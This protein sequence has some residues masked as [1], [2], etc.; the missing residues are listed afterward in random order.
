MGDF[1][2]LNKDWYVLSLIFILR[3][4]NDILYNQMG[5]SWNI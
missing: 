2:I 1:K 5:Y 4:P 3:D